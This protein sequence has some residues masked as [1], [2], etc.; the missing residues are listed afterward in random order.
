MSID[1]LADE[2][3]YIFE[4]T[5]S[6]NIEQVDNK[7]EELAKMYS[8]IEYWLT[9]AIRGQRTFCS[10]AKHSGKDGRDICM[11]CNGVDTA[12]HTLFPVW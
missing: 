3:S 6:E 4:N 8:T 5:G 1:L 2:R 12:E 7:G 11:Y 9:Q 10:Y